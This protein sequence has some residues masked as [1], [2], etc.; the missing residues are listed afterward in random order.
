VTVTELKK[1]F[2]EIYG[3]SEDDLRV[4]SAA[5][6]VN[7]IGE[8]IDYCGGKVFPAALNLRTTVI[9]RKTNADVIRLAATTIGDRVTLEINNLDAYRDL[10]WGDY[11]AGVAFVMQQAGYEIVGCDLLYDT[12]VPFGSGLSSSASIEV[13]TGRTLAAFSQEK[14]G[15]GVDLI[16]LAVLGQKSENTYNGVNCGIMD[17]FASSL[18]KKDNAIL[19]NCKTLEYDYIPLDL[20]DYALV[21]ANCNKPRSLQD[22][23]YNE[24]RAECEEAL[25]KLQTVIPNAT[26]LADISPEQ[27]NAVASSVLSGKVYD[28]AKHVVEEC[29]RVIDSANAL[30]NGEIVKFG[31]YLNQSHYSL[32]DLYEVTGAY[33]DA[34][35]ARS[36]EAEGCIGSRMTG[37]GFGGCTVSIVKKDKV[38]EFIKYVDEKY[39]ADMGV[40]ASFYATSIENG[41]QE[42]TE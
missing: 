15:K 8:H 17:Q 12:T 9:A 1:A 34:L 35:S 10:K 30:K 11:Q 20:G 2:V 5:G 16:D 36:R 18:G 4:F 31:E 21:I 40:R 7:L 14:G 37:A 23:K 38:D 3:G 25:S 22:S 29:A 39:F 32:R 19:L 26:C 41:A 6:R 13:A 42:I 33:L 27:F 28:R 24:R